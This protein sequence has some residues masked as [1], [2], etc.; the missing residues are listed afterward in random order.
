MKVALTLSALV[1]RPREPN[2][3]LFCFAIQL[4]NNTNCVKNGRDDANV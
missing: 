1:K 2:R 4:S 3:L